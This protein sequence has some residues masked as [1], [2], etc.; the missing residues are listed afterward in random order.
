MERNPWW[1]Q[2]DGPFPKFEVDSRTYLLSDSVP[3]FRILER[4][5]TSI[6][7][8]IIRGRWESRMTVGAAPGGVAEWA[9]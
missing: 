4:R 1:T 9:P 6:S 7:I 5:P 3:S 8:L 2:V